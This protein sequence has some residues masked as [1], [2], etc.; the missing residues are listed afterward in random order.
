MNN[1]NGCIISFKHMVLYNNSNCKV[2]N[3]STKSII[4]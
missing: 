1:F 4:K 3:K 2:I